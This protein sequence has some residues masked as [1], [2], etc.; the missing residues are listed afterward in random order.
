MQGKKPAGLGRASLAGQ[1]RV[2]PEGCLL[3]CGHPGLLGSREPWVLPRKDRVIQGPGLQR[4]PQ[5]A[6]VPRILTVPQLACGGL[7]GS[8]RTMGE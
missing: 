4:Q 8:Q 6:Q 5:G 1:P 2:A 7:W 3:R